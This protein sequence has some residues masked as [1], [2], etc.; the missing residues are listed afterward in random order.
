[1]KELKYLKIVIPH[2]DKDMRKL[3]QFLAAG[4]ITID[5]YELESMINP[6]KF[7]FPE[8]EV[9]MVGVDLNE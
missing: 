3:A 6:E 1:V 9:E 4:K 5:L 8:E 7:E 2:L